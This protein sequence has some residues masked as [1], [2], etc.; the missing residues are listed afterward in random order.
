MYEL[1]VNLDNLEK[2]DVFSVA[3]ALLYTLKD[4]PKY[5]TTSELFYLLDYDNF[6]KLIKYFGGKEI[7]IPTAQEIDSL[8]NILLLYQYY[9]I[10]K[11]DWSTALARAGFT[12]D[13]GNKARKCLT[14]FRDLLK[15]VRVGRNYD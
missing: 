2:R 13:E 14:I 15:D 5:R 9:D 1:P 8:L 12:P 11:L 7:R 10:E 6:L 3:T 4:V